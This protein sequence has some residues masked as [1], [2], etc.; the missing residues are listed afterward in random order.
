MAS[1]YE[2]K[3]KN[4]IWYQPIAGM[5]VSKKAVAGSQERL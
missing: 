5:F 3:T 4:G 1:F 2:T